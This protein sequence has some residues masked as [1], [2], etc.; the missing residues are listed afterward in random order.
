M[1]SQF[2]RLLVVVKVSQTIVILFRW[3]ILKSMNV[4]DTSTRGSR[5]GR[6]DNFLLIMAS[7]IQLLSQIS[8]IVLK[9]LISNK[10]DCG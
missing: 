5:Y 3:E 7:N 10:K 4:F 9:H 1:I 8:D 6:G 2:S